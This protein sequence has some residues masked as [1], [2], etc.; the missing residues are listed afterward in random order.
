MLITPDQSG[1]PVEVD[2]STLT[3]QEWFAIYTI[4]GLSPDANYA[5]L[6]EFRQQTLGKSRAE[7]MSL[8]QAGLESLVARGLF[9][10]VFDADGRPQTDSKGNIIYEAKG[11]LVSHVREYRPTMPK[12]E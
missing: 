12:F 4:N 8:L 5:K 10:P 11:R 2:A 3:P 1:R 6:N 7:Q 9:G